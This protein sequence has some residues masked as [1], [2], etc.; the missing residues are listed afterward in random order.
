MAMSPPL[1]VP[2]TVLLL[3]NDM[4]VQLAKDRS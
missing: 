2:S 3:I 1:P 4:P